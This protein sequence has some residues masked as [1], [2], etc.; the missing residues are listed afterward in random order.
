MIKED[1]MSKEVFEGIA[2]GLR[3]A[4]AIQR[5]EA[6]PATYRVHV[7]AVVNVKMT[8][9]KLGLTQDQFAAR[10]GFSAGAVRD[11]EQNRKQPEAT[12]RVLLTV[13]DREPE[14][15]QRALARP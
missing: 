1:Q 8:R 2:A 6:D 13:I 9:K 14:A 3:D 11:W 5:G 10:F 12:A 15:V 7:P 4:L